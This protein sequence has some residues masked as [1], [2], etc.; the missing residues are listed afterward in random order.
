MIILKNVVL[1]KLFFKPLAHNTIAAQIEGDD[2]IID[3]YRPKVNV[4]VSVNE[5][6][7]S[8]MWGMV[9]EKVIEKA[10]TIGL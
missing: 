10:S 1:H 9:S 2:A 7:V 5:K 8:L 4:K 3:V 6:K